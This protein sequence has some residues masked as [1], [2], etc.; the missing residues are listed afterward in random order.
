MTK[1]AIRFSSW[2][3]PVR[4][5]RPKHI[6]TGTGKAIVYKLLIAIIQIETT[7]YYGISPGV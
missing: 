3:G 6:F 2:P 7:V 1:A 5:Q 4:L